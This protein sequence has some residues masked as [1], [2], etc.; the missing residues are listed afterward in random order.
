MV[1]YDSCYGEDYFLHGNGS[2]YQ[3]FHYMGDLGRRR[4]AAFAQAAEVPKGARILDYGCGMGAI[5]VG[6]KEQGYNAIGVDISSWPIEHCLPQARGLV[7]T[8]RQ[9]PLDRFENDSFDAV[10]IKDVFE[11]IPVD[12]LQAIV[13]NMLQIAPKVV[14]LVPISDE[15][16]HFLRASDERDV[17]HITRLTKEQW[18]ALF[19]YK[20]TECPEALVPIKGEHAYGSVCIRLDR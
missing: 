6:L 1:Q 11:H 18:L 3:N 4:A 13:R 9:R 2:C 7:F 16:G 8:L 15:S 12:R 17:S 10:I 19:P 20:A 14:F 5:T